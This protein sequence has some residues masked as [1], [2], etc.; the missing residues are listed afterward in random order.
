MSASNGVEEAVFAFYRYDPN[1]A[2]AV[3]FTLLFIGTTGYHIFQMFKSRTWF[4][5]PFVIGGICLCTF[6]VLWP[7]TMLIC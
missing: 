6:D 5:V 2:A 4:F 1:M 3:L 7:E